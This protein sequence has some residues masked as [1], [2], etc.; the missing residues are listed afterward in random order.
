MHFFH[1]FT[2]HIPHKELQRCLLLGGR[3]SRG[4]V[5]RDVL[6]SRHP[7]APSKGSPLVTA[8][9]NS[10]P[11]TL[12]FPLLYLFGVLGRMQNEFL[13]CFLVSRRCTKQIFFQGNLT[14]D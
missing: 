3:D 4:A 1:H 6:L 14:L 8:S 7:S 2:V 13:L 5:S 12:S 9:P 10:K 11:E